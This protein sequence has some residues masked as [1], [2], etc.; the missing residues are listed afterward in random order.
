VNYLKA[1]QEEEKYSVTYN[2]CPCSICYEQEG[3]TRECE[4]FVSFVRT[5]N[6]DTRKIMFFNKM[7]LQ[8]LTQ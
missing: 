2:Y 5:E 8:E 1:I 3:C 6:H 4:S 7:R